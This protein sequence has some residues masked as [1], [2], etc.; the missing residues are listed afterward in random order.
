M[1]ATSQQRPELRF[2]PVENGL[3]YLVDVTNRLATEPGVDPTPRDLKY[4]VR[5]LQDATETLLKARL[6][7]E[8]W[9]LVV[10]KPD[11]ATRAAFAKGDFL[12][13]TLTEAMGRLQKIA[14]VK[15]PP[16]GV[17][18]VKR[19]ARDRNALAHWGLTANAAAIE[20]RAAAVLDFLLV[21]LDAELLPGL[22]A[23][24]TAVAEATMNVVR[25]QLRGINAYVDKRTNDIRP[26]L[27][28][29]TAV[30][31]ECPECAQPTLVAGDG[32]P[33]CRFCLL[34]WLDPAGAALDYAWIVR[35]QTPD[36]RIEGLLPVQVCPT[37]EEEA[38]V[39]EAATVAAAPD[40]VRLCLGC[41]TDHTDTELHACEGGCGLLL[42]ADF[43]S[44]VCDNCTTAAWEGF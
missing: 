29:L 42:P 7:H 5:S 15:L 27:A 31:V 40:T 22:D 3:D 36:D 38:L 32:Q 25:S 34:A 26:G 6:Q 4:A 39:L 43:A 19:L 2:P 1:S 21:F 10:A 41:G 13:C 33:A 28:P 18:A 12:S 17:A 35:G 16:K 20:A 8:H 11:G 23:A 37:C 9:A 30:T 44:S 24:E 14:A